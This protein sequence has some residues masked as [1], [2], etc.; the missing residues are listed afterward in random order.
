MDEKKNAN[1]S[2]TNQ[3]NEK[4]SQVQES[5]VSAGTATRRVLSKRWVYPA[6]YL[7]AA[8]LIIGLMYVKSQ[9]GA[10]PTSTGTVDEGTS[11]VPTTTQATEQWVWPAAKDTQTKVT[12]GFFPV[13]GSAQQ[14]AGA[15]VFY[16][17]GYYPHD[18]IDIKATNGQ[19]FNVVAALSGRVTDVSDN[20]L[21]GKTVEVQCANGYTVRYASLDQVNVQK[22]DT[23]QQGQVIGRSGTCQ[24]EAGQGNHLFFQVKKD[25]QPVDPNSVLPR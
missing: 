1:P 4:E 17:N 7:G 19:P 9:M 25:G 22:G 2:P 15:L 23:V 18:G 21:Y 10:S 24:F 13:Q 12:V 16:D 5:L 14:Q 6:I 3:E 20:P 8:A 11:S